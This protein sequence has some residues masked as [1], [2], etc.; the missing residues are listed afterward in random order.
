M[1]C[2]KCKYCESIGRTEIQRCFRGDGR[3]LYYCVHPETR[4]MTDSDG[5]PINNFIGH[6]D[7]TYES[8][9]QLKSYK[10]FCPLKKVSD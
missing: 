8:P 1:K 9:L 5:Y 3:K 2:S 7:S 10:N 4:K 6:G